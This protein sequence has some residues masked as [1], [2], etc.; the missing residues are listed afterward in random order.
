MS[1]TNIP[2]PQSAPREAARLP[3]QDG[4]KSRQGNPQSAPFEGPAPPGRVTRRAGERPAFIQA[5]K[6][7]R[8]VRSGPFVVSWLPS[9]T[10]NPPAWTYSIGKPVGNA[11]TRNR[12]RRRLREAV[13]QLSDVPPG[14]YL[15]RT[16]PYAAGLT[17]GEVRRH[18]A[19]TTTL[20]GARPEARWPSASQPR[21]ANLRRTEPTV[22][23]QSV[24][25]LHEHR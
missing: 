10:L 23:K 21:S 24:G 9:S 17:F 2:A 7:A 13:R 18:L 8:T 3:P 11:V 20:L 4:Y 16:R 6:E 15:I 12:L 5:F 22:P 25:S 1:E 14:H 19:V